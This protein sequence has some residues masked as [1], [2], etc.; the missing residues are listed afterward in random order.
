[1]YPLPIHV[2]FCGGPPSTDGLTWPKNPD[3]YE[4]MSRELDG[5]DHQSRSIND[6][7]RSD[8]K[9]FYDIVNNQKSDIISA[10]NSNSTK[11]TFSEVS[12]V[13]KSMASEFMKS[14]GAIIED[15]TSSCKGGHQEIK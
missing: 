14:K 7:K 3:Y 4:D 12:P 15:D 1:M 11:A 6:F 5:V 13:K 10:I 8:R 9:Q 2:P